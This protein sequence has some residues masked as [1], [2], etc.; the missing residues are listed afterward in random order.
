MAFDTK[1]GHRTHFVLTVNNI[2]APSDGKRWTVTGDL[3]GGV[4]SHYDSN[5]EIEE[6]LRK[7]KVL[8]KATVTDSEYS[9]FWGYFSTEKAAKNFI[10]RFNK[11]QRDFTL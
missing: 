5:Y 3:R 9:Q 1:Q 4:L 8:R 7:H 10:N 11:M 2:M 6:V